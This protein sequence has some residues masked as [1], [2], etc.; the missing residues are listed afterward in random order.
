MEEISLLLR[1]GVRVYVVKLSVLLLGGT[2]SLVWSEECIIL[3]FLISL[4]PLAIEAEQ[5]SGRTEQ[6][7]RSGFLGNEQY[8][9]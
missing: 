4:E 7:C 9:A 8:A 2:I 5:T 6:L 1:V 3:A